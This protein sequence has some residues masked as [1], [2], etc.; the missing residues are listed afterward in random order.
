M[1]HPCVEADLASWSAIW[2]GGR[3]GDAEELT[4]SGLTFLDRTPKYER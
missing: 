4:C 3:N 1:R 2:A